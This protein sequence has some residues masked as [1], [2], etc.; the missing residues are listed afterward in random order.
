MP[1]LRLCQITRT[2]GHDC[3]AEVAQDFPVDVCEVHALLIVSVMKERGG[4]A[5]RR[6]DAVYE[7]P[8]VTRELRPAKPIYK[9][10]RPSVVYYM[11]FG[12]R[13]KIGF[14]TNLRSRMATLCPDE[15]L[16]IEPGYQG[17]ERAQHVRFA[18]LREEG[19]FFRMN[20][21]LVDH[22]NLLRKMYG[23]PLARFDSWDTRSEAA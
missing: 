12:N 11:R 23:D 20:R 15:V 22:I 19:E 21:E 13:V 14:S 18:E 5:M 6:L 1:H 4:A 17:E 9:R 7:V 8:P 10:G 2:N 3:R 16:A